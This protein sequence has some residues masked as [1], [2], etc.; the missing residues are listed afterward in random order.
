MKTST[1]TQDTAM[2]LVAEVTKRLPDYGYLL[3]AKGQENLY[4][5]MQMAVEFHD[6]KPTDITCV[7]L[8]AAAAFS[9]SVPPPDPTT[10]AGKTIAVVLLTISLSGGMVELS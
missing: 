1:A 2:A 4:T 10:P 5:V 9:Q 7:A 6:I 8:D 3:T